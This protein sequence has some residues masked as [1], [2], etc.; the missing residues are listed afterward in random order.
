MQ[1]RLF[2]EE[3]AKCLQGSKLFIH[4]F[5]F[6]TTDKTLTPAVF[7]FLV[8]LHIH[9]AELDP[10]AEAEEDASLGVSSSLAALGAVADAAVGGGLRCGLVVGA[11]EGTAGFV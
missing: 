11:G 3:D 2:F 6:V 9:F 5:Y 7:F 10:M 8:R 1:H 4:V